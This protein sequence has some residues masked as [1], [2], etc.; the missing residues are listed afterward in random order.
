VIAGLRFGML[1]YYYWT[2]FPDEGPLGGSY[3]PLHHFF[4]F[5]PVELHEGWVL[6]KERLVTCVSGEFV[7]P[8]DT[9]PKILQFDRIGRKRE[10]TAEV[11]K[12][13]GGYRIYMRLDDW[14]E[15]AVVE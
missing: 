6:G 1:S 12:I 8:H 7:W 15:I 5:T 11:T 2:D 13:E 4:P 3:A 9:E 10:T 14:W